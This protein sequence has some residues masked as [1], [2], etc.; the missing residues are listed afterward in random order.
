M[1]RL[2]VISLMLAAVFTACATKASELALHELP[3]AETPKWDL[4]SVKG[5]NAH[6]KDVYESG[7]VK[8]SASVGYEAFIKPRGTLR[9]HALNNTD[10]AEVGISLK[11]CGGFWVSYMRVDEGLKAMNFHYP[12]GACWNHY[13]Q[14]DGKELFLRTQ[15]VYDDFFGTILAEVTK[16]RVSNDSQTLTLLGEN[17]EQLGVFTRAEAGQ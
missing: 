9:I 4:V 16:Y 8:G 6:L 15:T 2:F 10:N 13:G 1:K 5:L 12:E 11:T 7:T 17:D 14:K 3:N